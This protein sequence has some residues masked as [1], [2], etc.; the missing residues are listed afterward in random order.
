MDELDRLYR[1]VVHNVRAAFPELLTRSFEVSQLYQQVVPYRTNRRE[2][3]FDSNEEYEL[4]LMQLLAGLRGY[5]TGDAEMQKALRHELSSSNPDLTA[6]RVFATAS[7]SL[8]TDALRAL[9]HQRDARPVAPGGALAPGSGVAPVSLSPSEQAVL[10]ARATEA[11]NVSG[12]APTVAPPSQPRRAPT[13]PASPAPP[14][15]AAPPSAAVPRPPRPTVPSPAPAPSSPMPAPRSSPPPLGAGESCRYCGGGLPEGR[16]V[17]FC[18]SCGHNLTVQHCPACSTEL[19]VGW[20]FCITCGR[21]VGG[22]TGDARREGG[23]KG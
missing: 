4:A 8:T 20:K 5:V 12:P 7:I 22:D 18:P 19:E 1:R 9:E 10:A 13:P 11:V 14:S 2:L 17:T 15:H 23:G 3:E 21:G 6:F 16:R